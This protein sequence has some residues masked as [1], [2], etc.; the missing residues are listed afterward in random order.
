MPDGVSFDDVD[1][2]T[3]RALHHLLEARSV[4]RAA[5]RLGITQP[6]MSRTLARLRDILGD[7]LF[8]S[9]GRVLEPTPFALA[10]VPDVQR[11][12][13]AMRSVFDP[14]TDPPGGEPGGNGVEP[15]KRPAP[16]RG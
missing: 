9:S 10:L 12:L 14:A 7:P 5:R 3:L 4:T 11:A 16:G 8:V 2:N 13:S 1:F 15:G 6:S